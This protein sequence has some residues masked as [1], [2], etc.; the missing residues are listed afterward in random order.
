MQPTNALIELPRKGKALI[1]TDIHG[2][3]TDFEKYMSI[4]NKF[5]VRK[6]N[7]I[8]L[9]GD[10][11]HSMFTAEDNSIAILDSVMWH[12][13]HTNNFHVLLGN[14]EWSHISGVAVYKSGINQKHEF[15]LLLKHKF[16]TEWEHQLSI[17]IDFFKALPLAA[18]TQNGVF[19]SHAAPVK[20][21]S[22]IEDIIQL[23]ELG[24]G[25]TNRN[26]FDLLWNRHQVDYNKKHIKDFL[27]KVGCKVSVVGHTPVDGYAVMGNQIVLSSSFGSGKKC[28]MELD[29][30]KEIK[31][32]DEVIKMIRY[33]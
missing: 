23:K 26:L 22:G 1:V 24:Y 17:Y 28:Y 5:K 27:A 31:K 29:L 32:V 6:E 20:K 8:I 21:I 19:I 13:K 9:T 33:L 4:W 16:G 14:H 11:I 12:Y 7:H 25:L 18:K 2:D 10:Y 15:E 30:E 3:L